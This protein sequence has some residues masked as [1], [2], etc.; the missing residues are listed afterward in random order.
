M[1]DKTCRCPEGMAKDIVIRI[2]D[3]IIPADFVIL[4]VGEPKEVSLLLGRPFLNYANATIYV[5]SGCINFRVQGKTL[6][7]PFVGYKKNQKNNQPGQPQIYH[8]TFKQVGQAKS[9][10]TISGVEASSSNP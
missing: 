8:R 2:Q 1:A 9:S 4:D 7:C 3:K 6:K 5:S 10:T